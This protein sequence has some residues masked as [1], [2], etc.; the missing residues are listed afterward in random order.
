MAL[1]PTLQEI[2]DIV[3][4]C[5]KQRFT[6]VFAPM[7]PDPSST[8]KE[9]EGPEDYLIRAAQGHSLAIA[10]EAHLT[11]ITPDKLPPAAIHGTYLSAWP[12]I[13]ES[14][15]LRKMGRSHI[16]FSTIP[17]GEGPRGGA[18]GG[19]GGVGGGGVVSG[20]R[21]GAEVLIWVD[22]AGS[23]K[24]GVDWWV[25]DNGVVLTDGRRTRE[26][27]GDTV[28]GGEEEEMSGQVDEQAVLGTEWF[29]R[30][31]VRASGKVLVEK[32]QMVGEVTEEE[33]KGSKGQQIGKAEK[34]RG[35]SKSKRVAG[36]GK[37]LGTES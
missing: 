26:M 24:E 34:V 16:H 15:G 9:G 22:V 6:L 27:T 17:P 2:K 33:V 8:A 1:K 19:V 11:L 37:A 25:S 20:I 21:A 13:V 35:Q 30:A 31:V 36:R 29:D 32:G 7:S 3:R 28:G 12:A 5:P 14:G 10:A 4:S 18:V 23:M